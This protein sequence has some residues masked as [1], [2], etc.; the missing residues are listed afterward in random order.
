MLEVIIAVL[1]TLVVAIPL[2]VVITSAYRKKVTDAKIGSAEEKARGII[3]DALKAAEAKKREAELEI[4][5]DTIRSKNELDKEINARRADIQRSEHRAQ[6][7]EEQLDKK[8]DALDQK[9]K[10]LQKRQSILA[11]QIPATSFPTPKRTGVL[12]VLRYCG[13]D[14]WSLARNCWYSLFM[15]S[16]CTA[17]RA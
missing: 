16:I 15:G 3:D 13:S 7:R 6:Q 2:T 12:V 5:E 17:M 11:A 1:V 9:E 10:Q 4:K 14:H 8:M